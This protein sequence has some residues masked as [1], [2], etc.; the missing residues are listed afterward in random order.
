M[1]DYLG[2]LTF[3]SDSS[4]GTYCLT[5]WATSADN[6]TATLE[7]IVKGTTSDT[8][9]TA[10]E[11]LVAQLHQG[12]S[13]AHFQPGNTY[14]VVYLVSGVSGFQLDALESWHAFWQRVSFTLSLAGMPAGALTTLYN[15]QDVAAPASVS[16][17]TLLGTNPA[18]LDVTID[19]QA[20]TDMHGVWAALAP[21]AL[22]DA[23]WLVLADDLTWT[24]MSGTQYCTNPGFDG[25]PSQ[26]I[27]D[28]NSMTIGHPYEEVGSLDPTAPYPTQLQVLLGASWLVRNDGVDAQDIDSMAADA[29]TQIDPLYDGG[30]I[31]NVV[32]CW[33]GTNE[34]Y[35]SDDGAVAATKIA[36]YCAARQAAGFKVI[37]LTVLPRSNAGT[38]G[39]F[40]TQRGICNA[41]IRA[42]WATYA[43]ALADVAADSRIG[44]AGDET[45]ATYYGDL[46]HLTKAGYAIIADIVET[47]LLTI[48]VDDPQLAPGWNLYCDTVA[49]PLVTMEGAAGSQ[50]QRMRMTDAGSSNKQVI[51]W[52]T[53]PPASFAPG[54]PATFRI[55]YKGSATGAQFFI[56]IVS[57]TSAR[58]ELDNERVGPFTL[59][60][61]WQTD[62]VSIASCAA[63][64]DHIEAWAKFED[65]DS[66][67]EFDLSVKD[68][69][70][71]KSASAPS[72]GDAASWGGVTCYTTSATYQ[73]APLDTSQY[74][75]GKYR[76]LVRASQE[77][78]TGYVMD[79]Q[80]AV[81]VPITGA[82]QHL[83]V[84]G[85]LDLPVA[86]TAPGVAANLT[87]SVK[88]DGTNDCIV[89]AF[90]LLPLELGYFSWHHTTPT[91][92]IDQLDVGPSGVFMDGIC[93][94]TYLQGGILT[95]C[96]LAAHTGSLIVTASP[97]GSTWPA[98][99]GKTAAGVSADTSRFKCV[100]AS[101]DAWYAATNAATPLVIPGAWYQVDFTRDV[102][103][104][105][106]GDANVSVLW[107]DIDGGWIRIDVVS[108]TAAND[109][110]PVAIT[111]YAKAPVHAARALIYL[112]TSASGNLTAYFSAVAFRRCPLRL[113][114]V[115]EDAAGALTSYLHPVHLSVKYSARYEVA[116]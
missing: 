89:N 24:T 105:V 51:L 78:G 76:L 56:Y 15:A 45:N 10:M 86:D 2:P 96:T 81:A 44:D 35:Y 99:W 94:A 103:S 68:A 62:S 4:S 58:G 114:I 37:V 16:L 11:A 34:I 98:D 65:V 66:G 13:Y 52:G 47:A 102:D 109:A 9:A 31:H 90:V 21:T 71:Y 110:A 8:L 40:E 77:A 104:Y 43:D 22:S 30:L 55:S 75:A 97:T 6:S 79:S 41:A 60:G 111:A 5:K 23:K 92:E 93:D 29:A 113:I 67:D 25:T 26:L 115:A 33:E 74:P 12:N 72:S 49:N 17:A 95:A 57:R 19:D 85:D 80:N 69:G 42:D 50:V 46:V 39:D 91:T 48:V 53:S 59:T 54:D 7:L 61:A 14:P 32:A 107:V 106:A 83:V 70:V 88:S 100:G 101:K 20:G 73:T 36:D 84:V 27:C 63:T 116:R 108:T 18:M 28:G 112:R 87:L 64:T 38:P 82:T 1:T 3:G